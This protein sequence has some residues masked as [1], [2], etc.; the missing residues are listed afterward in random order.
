MGKRLI[1][2]V[3]ANCEAAQQLPIGLAPSTPLVALSLSFQHEA[4]SCAGAAILDGRKPCRR[5]Q[6]TGSY[7]QSQ[8]PIGILRSGARCVACACAEVN[9]KRTAG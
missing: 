9:A 1:A 3:R 6:V 4:C 5:E 8:K 2:D 7:S